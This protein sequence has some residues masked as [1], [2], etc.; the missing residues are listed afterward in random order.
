[1]NERYAKIVDRVASIIPTRPEIMLR[2]SRRFGYRLDPDPLRI[3]GGFEEWVMTNRREFLE[4]Q[5]S[6]DNTGRVSVHALPLDEN[7]QESIASIED[8]K[9]DDNVMH[10]IGI[11][12]KVRAQALSNPIL[13]HL[14][15]ES[16]L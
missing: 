8:V 5:V 14:E 16:T 6:F 13:K 7:S 12:E 3:V 2:V 11:V 9:V 1:M 10:I 4:I 15:L